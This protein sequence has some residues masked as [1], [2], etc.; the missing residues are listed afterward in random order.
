[1]QE[2]E[3]TTQNNNPE[4]EYVYLPSQ[5]IY[6]KGQFKGL[7]R[8]LVRKLNWTDDDILT[9]KSFYDNNTLY[10]MLLKRV[11]IDENKFNPLDLVPIDRDAILW[12]LRIGA[13]GKDYTAPVKCKSKD[14]E[15]KS[16]CDNVIMK[17]WDLAEFD[18]P[19]LPEQYAKEL[20]ETGG[21][22][23][24]LPATDL[25]CKITVS[26]I[27]KIKELDK[28]YKTKK[29][30]EKLLND[31]NNTIRLLSV[32]EEAYD[33]NEVPI[34]DSRLI[35][36]WLLKGNKGNPIPMIDTRYITKKS[37]EIDLKIDTKKDVKCS[38]CDYIQE[39]VEM[40]MS[41]YFFYPD[42]DEMTNQ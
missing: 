41:V 16:N 2:N 40:P 30:K 29:T 12:W 37:T 24:T 26:S 11:I 25:K 39:N 34:K 6:Y 42:F 33:E 38:E 18:M 7:K 17:T 3:T 28:S 32:I 31:F 20:T 22:V 35:Y 14:E 23:I 8:L 19:E 5:G 27:G 21:I 15:G 13:F 4:A 10:E 9:T 1:M 36:Q